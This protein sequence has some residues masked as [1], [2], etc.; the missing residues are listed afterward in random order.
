LIEKLGLQWELDA[1]A[2]RLAA[3]RERLLESAAA[4]R[5]RAE[6]PEALI[7][8]R[9]ANR[10]L[11]QEYALL[12][13]HVSVIEASMTW[14]LMKFCQRLGLLTLPYACVQGW[15]RI[16]NR[17]RAVPATAVA[18][19]A[20]TSPAMDSDFNVPVPVTSQVF[21]DLLK[22]RPA[23]F[24][25][26]YEAPA[27]MSPQERVL[28]YGITFGLAPA[29]YLEIGTCRGG[30]AVVVA[31]AMDDLNKGR[32]FGVDPEAAIS[33]DVLRQISHRFTLVQGASPKALSRAVDL[34]GGRFDFILVDGDHSYESTL[35]DLRGVLSVAEPGAVIL[36]H[37]AYNESVEKAIRDFLASQAA[38]VIDGGILATSRNPV[39]EAN[40]SHDWG[41]LR[42]L[43]ISAGENGRGKHA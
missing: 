13:G 27:L 8:A 26:V 23:S 12:R 1:D 9:R 38:R 35:A 18:N 36:V 41:G 11:Q 4:L 31:A 39:V 33:P 10:Q 42:L 30:S 20:T 14:R 15:R 3:N 19:S 17:L 7:E 32:A 43:R 28:L 25:K 6:N 5:Q 2:N 24:N 21:V 40:G 34:A 22:L 16:L 37:D 29:R